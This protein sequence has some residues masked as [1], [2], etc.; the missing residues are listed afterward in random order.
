MEK[1]GFFWWVIFSLLA[2]WQLPQFIVGLVMLPFLGK[3]KLIG[4]RH[5]NFCFVGEE[6]SGGISLG[7][8]AFVSPHLTDECSVAHELDGHTVDSKILGPL[9]LIVVGLPSLLNAIF[10][11]TD[12]YFD[13]FPEKWA[14][15]HAGL[16]VDKY[17][18]LCKKR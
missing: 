16:T 5:F 13:W 12:C 11:F 14:N 7:P 17:C 6:M 3:L 2:I 10:G 1:K 15:K 18:H 4:D 9:Y 8:L